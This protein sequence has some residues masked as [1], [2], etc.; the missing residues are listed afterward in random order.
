MK[1]TKKTV[2]GGSSGKLD[3]K[4]FTDS[5]IITDHVETLHQKISKLNFFL[6]ISLALIFNIKGLLRKEKMELTSYLKKQQI[7]VLHLE[8]NIS[9]SAEQLNTKQSQIETL[10]YELNSQS[11]RHTTEVN[12]LKQRIGELEL[13]LNESNKEA[14]EYHKNV[15]Q[16]ESEIAGLELKVSLN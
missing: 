2:D 11:R 10:Q 14:D 12:S 15:I 5:P 8:K 3:T 6:I 13:E 1:T 7:R 9:N 4:N 16:K